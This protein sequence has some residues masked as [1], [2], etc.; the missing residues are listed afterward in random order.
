MDDA[1]GS[2]SSHADDALVCPDAITHGTY[3]KCL[4]ATRTA[5]DEV[6]APNVQLAQEMIEDAFLTRVH[7]TVRLVTCHADG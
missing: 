5:V 4:P 1:E 7:P 2:R 3:Q 6:A